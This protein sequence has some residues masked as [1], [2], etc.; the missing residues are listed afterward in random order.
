LE[1]LS[2]IHELREES[3]DEEAGGQSITNFFG[4][5]ENKKKAPSAIFFDQRLLKRVEGFE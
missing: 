4:K 2:L 5:V 3:D 1:L